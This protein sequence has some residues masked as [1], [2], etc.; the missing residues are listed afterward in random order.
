MSLKRKIAIAGSLIF[1]LSLLLV[2]LLIGAYF[3]LPFYLETKVIPQLAADTGIADF[4]VNVRNIGFYGADLADLRLGPQ[5]KPA[6]V[7]RSAQIDYTPR[8]LYQQKIEKITLSGIDLHGELVNGRFT[9]RGVDFEK[10]VAAQRREKKA[11]AAKDPSPPVIIERL[12]IRDSQIIIG[13]HDQFYR[14]PFEFDIIPQDSDYNVLAVEALFY[15][16][17]EKITAAIKLDR[18]QQKATVNIDSAALKLD[19]FGD[20]TGRIADLMLS[21]EMALHGKA[22]VLWQPLRISSFNASLTLQHA[23][24]MVGDILLQNAMAA[25]GKEVPFRIDLTGKSEN[26]WQ[27]SGSRISMVAP[28]LLTLAGVDGAIKRNE[29]ALESSGNFNLV[30][31]SSQQT[32]PDLLP[33]RFQDPLLLRSRFSAV[34]HQSGKWQCEVSNQQSEDSAANAVRLK[35]EPYTITSSI[36]EF[37]LSATAVSENIDAVY[38]LTVPA[39]RIASGSESIN[40]PKLLLKGTARIENTPKGSAGVKFDLRAPNT[41]IKLKGGE[42]TISDVAISGKLNRDDVRQINLEG[43]MQFGGAGGRF[44]RFA[45]RISGARGQDTIH[46][47][48]EK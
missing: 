17:G 20:L 11:P 2:C 38:E 13:H 8:G 9:L 45:T 25:E 34:Y 40:I 32:G 21:G 14:I 41:G 10:I 28:M 19:R 30:L 47:A 36:P 16:R 33:V 48:G 23:K 42:I 15:P 5:K 46:V 18:L 27:F 3:Y 12:H 29:A 22:Q 37:N 7:I 26:E 43:L 44:S 35:I 6:L 4:A 31:H 1:L 24:I 39:V